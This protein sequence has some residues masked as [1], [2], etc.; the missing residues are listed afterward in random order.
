[1]TKLDLTL[2]A[3]LAVGLVSAC[4]SGAEE[5][6]GTGTDTDATAGDETG[7]TGCAVPTAGPTIHDS[8]IAPGEVWTAEAGP[9]IVTPWVRF[10]DDST[11]TIAA[12]AE[13]RMQADAA[14]V[15][16]HPGATAKPSLRAEGEPGRPIR[17]VRDGADPWSAIVVYDPAEVVLR[18]VTLDGGGAD[19]FLEHS[20]LLVRGDGTTPTRLPLRVEHVTVQNSVGH[21]VVA[22]WVA[23]FAAGSTDLVVTGCGSEEHPQGVKLGEHS[24]DTLPTG[25]Y[26]GNRVDEILID[27]EGANKTGGLQQDGTIHDRGAPYHVGTW[28][29]GSLGIGAGSEHPVT[30]LTIEPGVELRFEPGTAFEIEHYTSDDKPASGAVVAVGTPER[31][32]VFTSAAAEPAPGDWV[33]LWFGGVPAAHNRIDHAR[34]EYAGGECGC[35]GFTC[36]DADEGSVL[37]IAAAPATSFITHTV[38]SGGKNHGFSRGWIGPGPDFTVSNRFEDVAGCAQTRTRTQDSSCY[39]NEGCG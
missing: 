25:T 26:T 38:I 23:G 31:P 30:T 20:S 17:F 37:F 27:P 15:V 33:G 7:E 9:H 14:L 10:A 35:V 8:T 19:R 24:L 21:G 39:E 22:E 4:D 34:I 18:H 28:S 16:G 3:L 1:M 13:V 12:C 5:T 32:I 6:T 29:G 2:R 11:L 36:T